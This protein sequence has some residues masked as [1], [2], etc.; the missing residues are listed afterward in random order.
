[1]CTTCLAAQSCPILCDPMDCSSPGSSVHGDSP[2]RVLQW[3]AI[4]FSR[5]SSQP[6]DWTQVSCIAADS[7]PSE[8]PGKHKNTGVDSLSLLQGTFPT[9]ESNQGLQDC[10]RIFYQLSYQESPIWD[11]FT[12]KKKKLGGGRIFFTWNSNFTGDY[13]FLFANSSNP[14]KSHIDCRSK[15]TLI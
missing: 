13:V 11:I 14:A 9:Q 3:V 8:P 15:W 2:A 6:R 7:L 12:L 5:G 1:M 4:P 10:R